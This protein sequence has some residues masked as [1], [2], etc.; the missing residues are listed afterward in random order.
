MK[1]YHWFTIKYKISIALGITMKIILAAILFFLS[2]S[3][4]ADDIRL[5]NGKIFKGKVIKINSGYVIY[6]SDGSKKNKKVARTKVSQV[7]FSTGETLQ[8]HNNPHAAFDINAKE[9]NVH[10]NTQNKTANKPEKIV[11]RKNNTAENHIINI[12]SGFNGDTGV[13]GLGY[14]KFI[15]PLPLS[16]NAGGGYG[17]WGVRLTSGFRLYFDRAHTMAISAAGGY[18]FGSKYK[19]DMDVLGPDGKTYSEKVKLR[20]NP[21]AT[22]SGSFIY[23]YHYSP[24]VGFFCETGYCYAFTKK[25]YSFSKE[26]GY[27]LTSDAKKA[28]KL[29]SPKGVIVSFG[30]SINI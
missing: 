23:K 3:V 16:F 4:F 13:F 21:T 17:I 8:I 30:V 14:E 11:K 7:V 25:L 27:P 22:V 15:Q 10:T 6:F 12:E 29:A 1:Y 20:C 18:N 5:L 19:R 2:T 28:L 26:T 24:S 9:N